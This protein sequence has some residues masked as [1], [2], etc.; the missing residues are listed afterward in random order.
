MRTLEINE[1]GEFEIIESIPKNW[2]TPW[3]REEY[4]KEGKDKIWYDNLVS[5]PDPKQNKNDMDKTPM[6]FNSKE[7]LVFT[8]YTNR[9]KVTINEA[10]QLITYQDVLF[11]AEEYLESEDLNQF[12]KQANDKNYLAMA[13]RFNI[14]LPV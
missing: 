8:P 5:L 10:K 11:L 3:I 13:L 9:K 1:Q 4:K 12:R 6:A 2:D 14:A 7:D